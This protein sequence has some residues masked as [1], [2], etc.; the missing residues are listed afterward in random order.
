VYA[1][2]ARGTK[3]PQYVSRKVDAMME[4]LGGDQSP[5]SEPAEQK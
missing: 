1:I 5:S 4:K 3:S 2:F